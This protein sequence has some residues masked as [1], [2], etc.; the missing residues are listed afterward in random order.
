[1]DK[2]RLLILR[3]ILDESDPKT[4]D[5]QLIVREVLEDLLSE[6][7][8]IDD[9]LFALGV[10]NMTPSIIYDRQTDSFCVTDT[11]ALNDIVF[12]GEISR[13]ITF[14]CD[15]ELFYSDIKTALTNYIESKL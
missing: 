6:Q 2:D 9:T 8:T 12:D 1:M 14:R 13:L 10:V 4:S 15:A 3:D 11:S 7:P 5:F